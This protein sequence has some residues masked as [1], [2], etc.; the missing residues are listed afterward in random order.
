MGKIDIRKLEEL[1]D[2]LVGFQK[3][4]K[5]KATETTEPTQVKKTTKRHK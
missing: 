4:K 3:I 2:D 5:K 1:N